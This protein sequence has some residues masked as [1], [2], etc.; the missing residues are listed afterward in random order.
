[1][2]GGMR[3]TSSRM[4][5]LGWEV[6]S[7]GLIC[8][9]ILV[10]FCTGYAQAQSR[11]KTAEKPG[12]KEMAGELSWEM[13][14]RF[15]IYDLQLGPAILQNNEWKFLSDSRTLNVESFGERLTMMVR[16]SYKGSRADIPLKFVIKLPGTRQYEETVQLTTNQGQYSYKFTIH[17]PK[18]FVGNGSVYLYFGFSI[19]DALDFTIMPGG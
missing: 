3:K 18:D 12:Q 10:F 14:G 17:N 11:K 19:V 2:V 13:P 6:V 1:M 5:M 7:S 9:L 8:F 16:F 4:R 15:S